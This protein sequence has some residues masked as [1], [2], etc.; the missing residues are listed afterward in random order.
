MVNEKTSS[1]SVIADE[2][3]DSTAESDVIDYR[4]VFKHLTHSRSGH[5]NLFGKKQIFQAFLAFGAFLTFGIGDSVTCVIMM[6]IHGTSAEANPIMQYLLDTQGPIGLIL[7]KL[8]M[9]TT[10]LSLVIIS[11]YRSTES[12]YWATNGFL[13]AFGI[14][15]VL[16]MTSN[17]MRTYSFDILGQSTPSPAVVIL[18]Y[19]LLTIGLV[20]FG[21]VLDNDGTI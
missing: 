21:S 15:G 19:L 2:G 4:M 13:I 7:F 10:I 20:S 8:W 1:E 14:G 6:T 18:V 5:R 12:T 11:Q 9:T 3:A 16:A 17:L